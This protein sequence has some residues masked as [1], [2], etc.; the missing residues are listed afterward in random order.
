[1]NEKEGG[2]LFFTEEWQLIKIEGMTILEN[3]YFVNS[4][5]VSK[6][7][8]LFSLTNYSLITKDKFAFMTE[9]LD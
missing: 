3:H 9:T 1:M 5:F 2:K 7:D 6:V 8:N 4:Q